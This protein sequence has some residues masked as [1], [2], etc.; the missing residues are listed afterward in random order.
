[1]GKDD[2][3]FDED[4]DLVN[5]RSTQTKSSHSTNLSKKED[6]NNSIYKIKE[7]LA[8]YISVNDCDLNCKRKIV[9]PI[10]QQIKSGLD[11]IVI[12]ISFFKYNKQLWTWIKKNYS[13]KETELCI[14]FALE[15]LFGINLSNQ[16][17]KVIKS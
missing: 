3:L 16:K 6:A 8:N 15:E 12:S 9:N 7:Q 13:C 1:M 14:R 11:V 17:I 5:Q 4:R 2:I 10:L